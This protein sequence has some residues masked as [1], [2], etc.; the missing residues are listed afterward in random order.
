MGD[1]GSCVFTYEVSPAES[2]SDGV[3]TAV[4]TVSGLEPVAN[5]GAADLNGGLDPLYET[6]D[7]DTL[8]ALF[9][10]AD[11]DSTGTD[12]RITFTYHGREVTAHSDGRVT[13]RETQSG[14]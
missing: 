6:V 3:V 11:G 4:S 5:G 7:P 14:T 10:T 2:L 13:C 1:D 8:D 12:G 9:R